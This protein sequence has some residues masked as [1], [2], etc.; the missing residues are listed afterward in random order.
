[1]T[2]VITPVIPIEE[3][4]SSRSGSLDDCVASCATATAM[5]DLNRDC[6][7]MAV[8]PQALHAQLD[9]L[10]AAEGLP[11]AITTS[12]PHLFSALPFYVSRRHLEQVAALV[13]AIEKVTATPAFQRAVMS[14]APSIACFDPGSPGG[15]LGF[16]VHLAPDGPKLIEINTN[17]GGALLNAMLGKAL[18]MCMPQLTASPTDASKVED[19]V[20][21]VMLE[22]WR[23][24][25]GDAQLRFV[26]IVDTAPEQQYLYPE[27]VLY[28]ELFR[29]RGY[30]AEICSPTDLVYRDHGLRLNGSS[31]D[32]VYNRLTDFSLASTASEHLR[33]AY[34]DRD[35][36]VSPHPR[37]HALYADK[38]NL[39]LLC[40]GDFLRVAGLDPLS[41]ATLLAAVPVTTR[42]TSANRDDLWERRRQLFFKPAA[43]F[44]SRASYR[45]GKLTRG[46]W[47]Q[48]G[49]AEYVA[50]EIVRPSERYIA[51]KSDALKVDLRCYAYAG[52]VL[53]YAARM[54]Q[55]QTTNLRT[56]GGGFAPVLTAR[57]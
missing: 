21:E 32:L 6:F 28:R 22:E 23:L 57:N 5:E 3:A 47:E 31:V 8:D 46:V 42:V 40:D 45:G 4:A 9:V 29:A 17:P 44:G 35:V 26:A 18:H 50:Q 10:L 49:Q 13:I 16:D 24:Q 54:Y 20:V 53:L 39:S 25:R 12:H 15:L 30:E 43:G 11:T 33:T 14:W 19:Q 37:G 41:A 56:P 55:G 34:L 48:I 36:V 7:C 27:F 2:A 51:A 38:R 1:M 52:V